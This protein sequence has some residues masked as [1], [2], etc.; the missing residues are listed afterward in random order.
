MSGFLSLLDRLP[1]D[2]RGSYARAMWAGT[3]I[4]LLLGIA[5]RAAGFGFVALWVFAAGAVFLALALPFTYALVSPLFAG[6]AGWL[7]DMLPLVLLVG[8]AAVFLR[9]AIPLLL[10]RRWPF[11]GRWKWLP[12]ALV[13]WTALGVVVVDKVDLKGFALVLGMQ[14]LASGVVLAC[15]DRLRALEDRL[16]VLTALL[17]YVM[18][19]SGGVF[20]QW[21]GVNLEALQDTTVAGRAEEAYGLDA[22]PNNIGMIKWARSTNSGVDE[23]KETMATLARD[24]PGLPDYAAFRPKFQGYSGSLIVRFEGSARAFADELDEVGVDLIHDSVGL[25]PANTVPRMR[26]FPRNALTFAGVG[27]ALF[28]PA[29]ALMFGDPRK[30]RLAWAGAA[31]ALFGAAFSLARGA[32]VAVLA[33][34]IYLWVDGRVDRS[35]KWKATASFLAGAVILSGTYLIKYGVDPVTGRAGGGA[36]V[37]TRDDL[38]GDTIGAMSGVHYI[39]G[40]GVTQSRSETG[41][42]REGTVGKKYVPRSGTHSTYLNYLFRTGFP[43]AL[44]ILAL[45]AASFLFARSGSRTI[46][47]R[48]RIVALFLAAGVVTA[49]AHAVILS[50]YVEPVYMLVISLLLGLAVA[51]MIDLRAPLIPWKPKRR[52]TAVSE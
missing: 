51:G 8:W 42:T 1:T 2:Q 17:V 37:S 4:C 31:A 47:G 22:F 35:I 48:E 38:Y 3:W 41:T 16:K 24:T 9:W 29:F 6:L 5:T 33:G 49:A 19:L 14:G 18:C 11:G 30:R 36:S 7:V 15:V 23:L 52:T 27:A 46:E 39:V 13:A 25:A 26:S 40:Y 28:L 44:L 34:L 45:Y 12:I 21:S 20:L 43:G 50:L 32:W 10:A